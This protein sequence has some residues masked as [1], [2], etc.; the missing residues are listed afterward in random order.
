LSVS[1]NAGE[2]EDSDEIKLKRNL[3]LP[4]DYVFSVKDANDNIAFL[5]LNESTDSTPQLRAATLPKL[6]ERLTF[7]EYVGKILYR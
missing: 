4:P 2:E 1:A 6:I 7:T 3:E 5:P